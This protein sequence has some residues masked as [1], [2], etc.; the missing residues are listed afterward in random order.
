MTYTA[1]VVRLP[2]AGLAAIVL[3]RRADTPAAA[4]ADAARAAGAPA[5]AYAVQVVRWITIMPPG[6]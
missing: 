4:E 6:A 3:G 1:R 5:D 2:L